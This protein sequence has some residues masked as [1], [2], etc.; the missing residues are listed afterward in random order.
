PDDTLVVDAPHELWH[1]HWQMTGTKQP[2]N[3]V[4]PKKKTDP[5][6]GSPVFGTLRT[7]S[8]AA[9]NMSGFLDAYHQ[10]LNNT[11]GEEV[12]EKYK[13]LIAAALGTRD[14]DEYA[15]QVIQGFT[16]QALPVLN[17]LD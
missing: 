9:I 2:L 7:I 16:K 11:S 14:K 17:T 5:H 8:P 6:L 4:P 1:S 12:D 15:K 13:G 10:R 3:T